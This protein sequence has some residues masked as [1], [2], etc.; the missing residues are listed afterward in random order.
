MGNDDIRLGGDGSITLGS[1]VRASPKM[2]VRLIREPEPEATEDILIRSDGR[3]K[4][5]RA[6]W[7]RSV[8][9]GR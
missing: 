9:G 3:P 4:Q 8:K 2:V 7:R 1:G 6:E 5:T